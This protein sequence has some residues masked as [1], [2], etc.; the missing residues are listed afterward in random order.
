VPIFQKDH[1]PNHWSPF[2]LNPV[3]CEENTTTIKTDPCK[4]NFW[5]ML[6]AT[7]FSTASSHVDHL[8]H[9]MHRVLQPHKYITGVYSGV[10]W[11]HS[12]HRCETHTK[13]S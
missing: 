5:E 11:H 9:A 8:A 10:Q 1:P 6:A 2:A 4:M 13:A 12:H 7:F 3:A